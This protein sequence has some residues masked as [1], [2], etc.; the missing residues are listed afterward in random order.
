[1]RKNQILLLAIFL[2]IGL[3]TCKT[4]DPGLPG[5]DKI[6]I[7]LAENKQ[8]AS[9][10][11]L[12]DSAR[13]TV[14]F[15]VYFFDDRGV[16][17][18]STAQPQF[19]AN[20]KPFSGNTF[21]FREPGKHVFTSKVNSKVSDNQIVLNVSRVADYVD[22]FVIKSLTPTLNADSVSHL[23]LGYDL[24]TKKGDTLNALDFT[25]PKLK[26]DGNYRHETAYFATSQAGK[27][28]LQADFFGFQSAVLQITARHPVEYPVVRLPLVFHIADSLY[29]YPF[30]PVEA[31]ATVNELYRKARRSIDPNQANAY[32]EFFLATVDPE[33]QPLAQPGVHKIPIYKPIST[34]EAL[35]F[36][37]DL[38][39][40]WCPQQYINVVMGINWVS[41]YEGR[42]YLSYSYLP[43]VPTA[44]SNFTCADLKT[45]KRFP[46]GIPAIRLAYSHGKVLAHELGHF[47]GLPHT[48]VEVCYQW[49]S[50][51]DVPHYI[52]E[53]RDENG[54]N[55]TCSKL[56]FVSDYVMG[57]DEKKS[58]TQDQVKAMHQVIKFGAYIPR[59]PQQSNGRIGKSLPLILETGQIID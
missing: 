8:P 18:T 55:L 42:E 23:P 2:S 40:Q 41:K 12:E 1:M 39:H 16:Y 4:T 26:V 24:I 30:D 10:Y 9:I 44:L 27:H 58:F 17:I 43:S 13:N 6:Q 28:Q 31:V 25:I 49:T 47:L 11:F 5:V 51:A 3:F 56:S 45:M 54:R 7:I 36:V 19:F 15:Q 37:N 52:N 35:T 48:F 29:D 33:G 20:G 21:T 34:D 38:L 32:I 53:A 22:R 59:P 46:G 14:S 50:I 57:Y